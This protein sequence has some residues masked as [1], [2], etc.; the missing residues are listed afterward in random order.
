MNDASLL[1]LFYAVE[2][3]PEVRARAAEHIARLR[4]KLPDVR[5]SWERADK[6][7]ITLK[8]FGDVEQSRAHTLSLAAER[9][10]NSIAP[11]TLVIADAG[12][13]PPRGAPRVLWLGAH[14][15]SGSLARLHQSLEDECADAG[16]KREP[17]PFH[18]HLTIARLRHPTGTH[19]LSDRHKELGFPAMEMA[20]NEIILM[21]SELGPH[22]SCYTAL[23]HHGLAL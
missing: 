12:A 6:L 3:S 7:H 18:P 17:R 9:T 21:R 13:F 10:A 19:N 4:E 1:R 23:S 5:A 22:G 8:F 20:V 16:F 11:F 2:L 15:S 14:D